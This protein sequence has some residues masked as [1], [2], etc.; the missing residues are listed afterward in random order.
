[1][2]EGP[3]SQRCLLFQLTFYYYLHGSEASR[4]Q[5]FLQAQGLNA[6]QTPVL[7]RSHHGE[8][9]T[10]WVRDRVDIQS[11]HPFRVR[12]GSGGGIQGTLLEH[13]QENMA[14][15][16]VT[17]EGSSVGEV[18]CVWQFMMYSSEPCRG[19]GAGIRKK[20]GQ[21]N[22]WPSLSPSCPQILLAGE[23]GPGGIV[24]LDDLI[25]SNYCRLAPSDMP[26]ALPWPAQTSIRLP[27]KACEPGHLSCGELCVPPEQLCD[28]QQQ[29]AE[30]EDEQKCGEARQSLGSACAGGPGRPEIWALLPSR[31][32]YSCCRHHRL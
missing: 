22:A 17:L 6:T 1:M 8:L 10:A 2:P 7:L 27:Q 30:G 24:G 5:L 21:N 3:G 16:I 31:A 20:T 25:M 23:T 28:F 14:C 12:L 26:K 11:A 9:G 13:A 15:F 19:A 32:G 29:C 18:E 4:F